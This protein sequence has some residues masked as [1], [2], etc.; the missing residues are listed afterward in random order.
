LGWAS[1]LGLALSAGLLLWLLGFGPPAVPNERHELDNLRQRLEAGDADRVAAAVERRLARLR[2]RLRDRRRNGHPTAAVETRRADLLD[3]RVEASWRGGEVHSPEVLRRAREALALRER[4]VGPHHPDLLGSLDNLGILHAERGDYR[5]ARHFFGRSLEIRRRALPQTAEL[6]RGLYRLG[7]LHQLDGDLIR[8][9]ALYEEALE[10]TREALGQ[11]NL[12]VANILDALG[13]VERTLGH[14]E[15]ARRLNRSSLELR[16]RLQGPD[17]LDVAYSLY[18]L[19][20]LAMTGGD[21]REALGLFRRALAIDRRALGPDHPLVATDLQSLAIAHHDLGQTHRARDLLSRALE[22]RRRALGADHPLVAESSS[23]LAMLLVESTAPGGA[24]PA[25]AEALLSRALEILEVS[26]GEDHRLA[27]ETLTG[28]AAVHW[29]QGRWARAVEEALEAEERARHHFFRTAR[30]L[31]QFEALRLRPA[32]AASGL[33]I[34]LTALALEEETGWH[35]PVDRVWNALIR[36]RSVVLNEMVRRRHPEIGERTHPGLQEVRQALPPGSALVAFATYRRLTRPGML[37]DGLTPGPRPRV[38]PAYMALVLPAGGAEPRAIPLGDAQDLET[39]VAAW[40]RQ[41]AVPDRDLHGGPGPSP[42][43]AQ[44]G[45]GLRQAVWDPLEPSLSGADLVLVVPDGALHRVSLATLPARAGR[46]GRYLVETGPRIHYLSTERDLLRHHRQSATRQGEGRS[47]LVVGAPKLDPGER[48]DGSC[49]GDPAPELPD[50]PGSSREIGEIASLWRDALGAGAD[51][52]VTRLTGA[53]AREEALAEEAEGRRVI[54]LAS[55]GFVRSEPCATPGQDG[56]SPGGTG[57]AGR[58]SGLVL[59]PGSEDGILYAEELANLDLQGVEWV[60]LSA[61]ETG[62]GPVQGREGVLGLRRALE[63]SGAET[64]IMSLWK[65]QDSAV[66]EW[67]GALYRER[68]AGAS[69]AAAVQAA[70]RT[71]LE[72]RRRDGRSD[73]P[74]FWGAFVASGGWR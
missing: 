23:Y 58:A 20:E 45:N 2:P 19:G 56:R 43:L 33:D 72:A 50:L 27:V 7:N 37:G 71:V 10:V 9:R 16:E 55:H 21:T 51:G 44:T 48:L 41:V 15:T 52:E 17:H 5:R 3:L 25:R 49:P 32:A 13:V 6:G 26:P 53:R 69:T 36:S 61:C 30:D 74:F 22:I 34:A 12:Q 66:R 54:H 68:L 38:D 24:E 8:A 35:V 63:M 18:H 1:G 31:T 65:V 14:R 39:L 29:L 59:S 47:L 67:M 4:L 73:H 62:L 42:A 64:L 11:E 46:N 70:S 57:G 60:V 40:Q 28:L